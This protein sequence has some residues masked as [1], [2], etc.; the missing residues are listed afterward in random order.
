[1]RVVT[2][3]DDGLRKLVQRGSPKPME[4]QRDSYWMRLELLWK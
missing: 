2:D 4:S 1:M 3:G